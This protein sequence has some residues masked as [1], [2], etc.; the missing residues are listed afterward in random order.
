MK[1]KKGLKNIMKKLLSC[2]LAIAML[3]T[4]ATTSVFAATKSGTITIS[5]PASGTVYKIYKILDV[6]SASAD[7]SLVTDR[8]ATG[9]ED[10]FAMP[11]VLNYVSI[12]T[13]GAVTAK[14]TFT[15]STAPEFAKLAFAY[16]ESKGIPYT[17]TKTATGG[18]VVFD[19]LDLGY[20]LVDTSVGALCGLTTTQPAASI[21]IKNLVPTVEKQVQED[22]NVGSGTAE[23]G[24]SNS[25]D[26]GQI[27]NF[28]VTI[29]AQAGAENY[30]FHDFMTE[31]LTL[32]QTSIKVRFHRAHPVENLDL[33]EGTHYDLVFGG[34]HCTFEIRFKQTFLDTLQAQDKIYI[35]YSAVVNENAVKINQNKAWVEYGDGHETTESITTTNTFGFDIVKTDAAAVM[36]DGAVFQLY[37]ATKTKVYDLVKV[38]VNQYRLATEE[39]VIAGVTTKDIEVKLVDGKAIANVFGFDSDVYYLKETQSPSGYNA[40]DGYK[41]IT[42]SDDSV[43]AIFD[44]TD[45]YKPGTGVHVINQKGVVLPTTGGTGTMMFITF[46][47]IVVLGA[48]VLLVTKKRM[49]MIED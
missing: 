37:N 30:V 15:Q 34:S 28:D 9:W 20:Y 2:L 29:N 12:D 21:S 46:G 17:Q 47:A 44:S 24:F 45:T 25:A 48:G 19:D 10:F 5:N 22:S 33:V 16:I 13:N 42:I 4:L 32:D 8:V 11:E 40:M 41:E 26:I 38:A 43:S 14:S 27:V 18:D 39:E 49:S 23:Y 7:Y 31:G 6:E 1:I 35:L 36:L 3:F